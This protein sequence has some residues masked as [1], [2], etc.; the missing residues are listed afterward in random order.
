V[1]APISYLSLGKNSNN[2]TNKVTDNSSS[3]STETGASEEAKQQLPLLSFQV[4]VK[5]EGG[6][7]A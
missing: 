5:R 2:N 4:P 1:G 3:S 6:I 7:W